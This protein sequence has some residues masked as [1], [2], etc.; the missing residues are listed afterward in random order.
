LT[1]TVS[2]YLVGGHWS[3]PSQLTQVFNNLTYVVNQVSI[4]LEPDQDHLIWKL[5]DSGDLSLKAAHLFKMQNCHDV[6]WAKLI[7]NTA[8][9][10]SK[11]LLVW[12]LMYDKIPTDENLLIRG[13]YLPSMCSICKSHVETTFHIFFE[14]GFAVKTW[15]WLAGCLNMVI[16]FTSMQDI[17]KL[18]DLNWSPQ[19]KVTITAAIINLINTLW[20]V[21]NQARFYNK[22]I[23]W[24]SAIALII[25]NTSLT[26]NNT[27]KSSSTSMRDFTF[28][29]L[30][31]ISIHQPRQS[32]LLEVIWQ[33]PL[34]DWLKCNIDGA[35]VGCPGSASCGGV[36][37]NHSSD[38]VLGF[39]EPLGLATSY[40]A[41]LCGAMR[42]IE[43]AFQ[44]D[45]HN[46]WIESDSTLVVSAF[47]SP[48]REVPWVLRNRW[49]NVLHMVSSM[50]CIVTHI[51]REGNQVADLM[52]NH[53]LTL[54]SIVYWHV[55]PLFIRDCFDKN[56]LGIPCFRL[57]S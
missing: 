33:P 15:S 35:V 23:P 42:A 54:A 12:R 46:I 45:W 5:S 25:S 9:P 50:N 57:C 29:K 37:R 40:F 55:A 3:L 1:S 28:L 7:W 56:K 2:D 31:S 24:N 32:Y 27:A 26:G 36:F 13:C 47:Q 38:F 34:F 17:W 18:C 53:G 8:I 48:H 21:R 43:I 10:P 14:C 6:H 16:Q 51:F 4:P 44:N 49:K 52:A 19:S 41:E 20:F 22:L 39:A 11:S 30:F